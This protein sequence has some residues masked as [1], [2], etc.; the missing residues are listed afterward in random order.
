MFTRFIM[1]IIHCT[2]LGPTN[3]QTSGHKNASY[4]LLLPGSILYLTPLNNSKNS[5]AEATRQEHYPLGNT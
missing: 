4:S 2:D 3:D 5:V 1:I